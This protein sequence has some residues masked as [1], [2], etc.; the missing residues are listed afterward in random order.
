MPDHTTSA[1]RR[2]RGVAGTIALL[3]ATTLVSCSPSITSNHVITLTFIR[4]GESGGNASGVVDTSVP[5]PDL[6]QRGI[7]EARAVADR[8]SGNHYDGVFAST[9]VRTQETAAYM[10]KAL[11]ERV[12]VLPGL[13]E[14]EAGAYEGKPEKLAGP[15]MF[16]AITQWLA[17]HRDARIPDGIDG[18]EFDKRFDEAFDAIYATGDRRPVAFSHGAAIAARTLMNVTNLRLDLLQAKPLPNTGYVVVRGDPADGWTLVDWN[19]TDI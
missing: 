10:A 18:N 1:A 7:T 9:M 19:G 6:T 4:H 17:G 14:I 2:C 12:D 13:R 15:S 8:L 5:G 16:A 11:H 3:L